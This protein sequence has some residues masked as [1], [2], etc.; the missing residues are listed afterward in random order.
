MKRLISMLLV[1]TVIVSLVAITAAPEA[2]S[3]N[4]KP[5]GFD[6]P[7]LGARGWALCQVTYTKADGITGKMK[8][9]DGFVIQSENG[10]KW[11]VYYKGVRV[12]VPH[13]YCMINMKDVF[14][15]M[16]MVVSAEKRTTQG[17]YFNIT[18]NSENI[19]E[20]LNKSGKPTRLVADKKRLYNWSQ[21][22]VPITYATAKR[23]GTAKNY[24]WKT[25]GNNIRFKFYDTFRPVSVSALL[26]ERYNKVVPGGDSNTGLAQTKPLSKRWLLSYTPSSHNIGV[27]I[28]VTLCNAKGNEWTSGTYSK[29]HALYG[30]ALSTWSLSKGKG[31]YNAAVGWTTGKITK[32]I[33]K[34]KTV[35]EIMREC[36]TKAGMTTLASEWWHYQDDNTKNTVAKATGFV[37]TSAAIKTVQSKTPSTLKNPFSPPSVTAIKRQS[38]IEVKWNNQGAY[39]Y[40]IYRKVNGSGWK[41]IA[42]VGAGTI[43]YV[44]SN[45]SVRNTYCYTVRCVGN[46]GKTLVSSYDTVGATVSIPSPT[47][48]ETVSATINPTEAEDDS[49]IEHETANPTQVPVEDPT[50]FSAATTAEEPTGSKELDD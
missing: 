21:Q 11:I 32:K 33:A 13:A 48:P 14:N 18:N 34:Q 17:V 8:P 36:F 5:T 43:R 47:E 50:T 35:T 38:G 19:Y 46:D 42:N 26:R 28:D 16:D 6:R 31:E 9:G 24:L 2:S 23:I 25:Y 20:Y 40:R 37:K 3:S 41:A 27:A 45:I 29:M 12:T 1:L 10:A 30:K 15:D 44:D 4:A 22:F 39:Q 49:T 7:I